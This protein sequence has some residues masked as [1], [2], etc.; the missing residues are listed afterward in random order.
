MSCLLGDEE[1]FGLD[2]NDMAQKQ[3]ERN[4]L[5]VFFVKALALYALWFF[6][7]ESWLRD[8]GVVDDWL[9]T[10]VTG[11]SVWILKVL[12]YDASM[13]QDSVWTSV[14]CSGQKLLNV[15]DSCNGLV[16]YALYGGFF[17]AFPGSWKPKLSFVLGGFV[18]IYL[19]NLVRIVAL[20]MVQMYWPAYL[21]F[22]HKYAFTLVVYSGV[23]ALWWWWVNH[24]SIYAS[25]EKD[26]VRKAS[27]EV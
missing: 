25:M 2:I 21:D 10:A 19:L 23:L 1:N 14:V 24:Y 27:V 12:G 16:L 8:L 3:S 9:T 20:S 15:A 11:Q 6:V 13:A 26:K 22:S 5:I 7:Y 18:A 4:S 17:I